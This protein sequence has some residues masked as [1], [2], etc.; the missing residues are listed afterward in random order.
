MTAPATVKTFFG[1]LPIALRAEDKRQGV[2]TVRAFHLLLLG[3]E[4]LDKT[5]YLPLVPFQ[6]VEELSGSLI[7]KEMVEVIVLPGVEGVEI[8]LFLFLLF[9]DNLWI[10]AFSLFHEAP[11]QSSVVPL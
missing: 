5:F 6:L 7:R 3:I 9:K 2:M 10:L 8:H 11:Q 1:D 4:T